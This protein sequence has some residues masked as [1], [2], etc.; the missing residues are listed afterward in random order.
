MKPICFVS[1]AQHTSDSALIYSEPYWIRVTMNFLL[2]RLVGG[3]SPTG[4]TWH[5]ATDWP[6]VAWLWWWRILLNEDWQGNPTYLEKTRPNANLSTKNPTWP[7]LGSIPPLSL[8]VLSLIKGTGNVWHLIVHILTPKMP[9]SLNGNETKLRHC[10]AEQER[11]SIQ[12]I[13]AKTEERGHA[14]L[15]ARKTGCNMLEEQIRCQFCWEYTIQ[16]LWKSNGVG[17]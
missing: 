5:S 1:Q 8:I 4:S 10:F 12:S 11:R 6:I 16:K 17:E 14:G 15:P 9:D 3:W 2:C 7:E 13:E